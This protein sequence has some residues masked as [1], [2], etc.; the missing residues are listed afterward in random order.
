MLV[1]VILLS[2]KVHSITIH[3]TKFATPEGLADNTV[4]EIFQDSKGYLW[5]GTFDGL[6]RYDGYDIIK[7]RIQN[8]DC[9]SVLVIPPHTNYN[10]FGPLLNKRINTFLNYNHFL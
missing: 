5:F 3:S 8:K 7:N 10:L 4:R 9:S 2:I 6:S 1:L